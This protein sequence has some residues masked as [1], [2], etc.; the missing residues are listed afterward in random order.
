MLLSL[1]AEAIDANFVLGPVTDPHVIMI[2][3]LL[4]QF[5]SLLKEVVSLLLQDLSTF[6][7][8]IAGLE[9]LTDSILHFYASLVDSLKLAIDKLQ[10]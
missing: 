5:C 4:K 2:K 10:I 8:V 3:I 9:G 1:A 6:K 7:A